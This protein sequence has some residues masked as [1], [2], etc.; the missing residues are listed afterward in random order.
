[1]PRDLRTY[2]ARLRSPPSSM[3]R[4]SSQVSTSDEIVDVRLSPTCFAARSG[5][6]AAA[7]ICCDFRKSIR[8]VSMAVASDAAAGLRQVA[9]RIDDDDA[10]LETRG[11][12]CGYA[13]SAFPG[14]TSSDAAAWKRSKP[15]LTHGSRSSPIERMLR[16]ICCGDSSKA[17]YRQRSPRSQAASAKCAGEAGLAGARRA[18]D[19]D[20]AAP[21]VA[22]AAQHR[23]EP[24]DAG[25]NPLVG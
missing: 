20:A 22:L 14:R 23:V 13:A 25:G 2:I 5:W 10:R 7:V 11:R 19:Q 6:S 24:R 15:F 16:M 1:M 8:R 18:R 3:S 9:D 17:K 21:V 12:A 4:S